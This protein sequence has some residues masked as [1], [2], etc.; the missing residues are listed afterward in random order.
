[1][2]SV[3]GDSSRRVE[4]VSGE[5][6]GTNAEHTAIKRYFYVQTSITLL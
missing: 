2:A 4:H 6:N 3:T 1:M 5:P